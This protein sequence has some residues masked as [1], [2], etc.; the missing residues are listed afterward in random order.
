MRLPGR[1][2]EL[3]TRAWPPSQ[4]VVIVVLLA[5]QG[6]AFLIQFCLA[7]WDNSFAAEYLALSSRGISQAYAW[8]F[9]TAPL[10]HV[11]VWHFLLDLTILYVFG[12]DI[13]TIIGR[14]QLLFLYLFGTFAGELGHL[15]LMPEDSILFA[16]SGGVVAV[17]AAYATMLPG[18]ELTS[19]LRFMLPLRVKLGSLARIALAAAAGLL[20]FDRSGA[21][22]HSVFIGSA[23]AGC[24]YAHLLGFGAPSFLQRSLRHRA[25]EAERLRLMDAGQFLS[26]RIDPLLEKIS[27]SGVASLSRREREL[28]AQ[29]RDKMLSQSES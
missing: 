16:A 9:F 6:A 22:A 12:R 19:L 21:I 28:L 18:L 1:K 23:A 14:R 17:F 5:L 27:R 26:E 11:N 2:A 4:A 25:A 7:S 3:L 15:F 10:L 20:V 8:Q 13:E 24:L 29:A